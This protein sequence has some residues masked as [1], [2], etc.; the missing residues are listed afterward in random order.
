MINQSV[1]HL[2]STFW[3]G[4]NSDAQDLALDNRDAFCAN[5]PLQER[6]ESP[7]FVHQSNRAASLTQFNPKE[8]SLTQ[9][10]FGANSVVGG[11]GSKGFPLVHIFSEFGTEEALSGENLHASG[12]PSLNIDAAGITPV[13]AH[14]RHLSE[15][16]R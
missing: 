8:F 13:F 11:N 2:H 1:E 15:I 6:S 7:R 16:L 4:G 9:A 5:C 14:I 3:S 10:E 12:Q